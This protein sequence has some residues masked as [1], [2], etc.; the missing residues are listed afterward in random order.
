MTSNLVQGLFTAPSR[1]TWKIRLAE[2]ILSMS[3]KNGD[4]LIADLDKEAQKIKFQL[5]RSLLPKNQKN[6]PRHRAL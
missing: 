4:I 5:K 2:E 3:I 6:Q 1:N